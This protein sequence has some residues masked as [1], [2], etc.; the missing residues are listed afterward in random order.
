MTSADWCQEGHSAVKNIKIIPQ[1][2]TNT[3]FV[4]NI[5]LYFFSIYNKQVMI[6]TK[7]LVT[8]FIRFWLC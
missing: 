4:K 3:T 1:E 2:P 5:L 6:M 8:S 7:L